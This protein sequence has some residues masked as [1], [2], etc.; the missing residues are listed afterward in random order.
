MKFCIIFSVLLCLVQ[1]WRKEEPQ[2]TFFKMCDLDGKVGLTWMEVE[3]CEARTCS[4]LAFGLFPPIPC[5]EDFDA[6]DS[7][8]DGTLLYEEWEGW[9]LEQQY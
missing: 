6:A 5:K 2:W 3:K 4:V 9:A 1:G 8:E 7:N